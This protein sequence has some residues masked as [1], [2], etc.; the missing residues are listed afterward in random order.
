MEEISGYKQD[1]AVSKVAKAVTVRRLFAYMKKYKKEVA[2]VLLLM[3][4]TTAVTMINPL[5]VKAAVDD[6]I[7][8][9]D[10]AGLLRL[11]ALA[12]GLNLILAVCLRARIL[13]MGKVSNY[14]LLEI[15]QELYTHIQSLGFSFFDKRPTGK[16]L[17][18]VIGD[19]NSLKEVLNNAVVTLVPEVVNILAVLVIMLALNIR[20]ALAG[21]AMLPILA[22]GM[23]VVEIFA[24]QRWQLHRQKNSNMNA[25]THEDFSGISVVQSF[26][27]EGKTSKN[28]GRLLNEVKDSFFQA[29]ILTDLFWPI[30][31]LSSGIGTFL[32][33]YWG[34]PLVRSG[35][36]SV[37]L[38]IAFI[39]YIQMFWLPIINLS[40]F[41]NQ[42][43]SNLA[44][45]ERV[46]EILDTEPEEKEEDTIPMPKIKGDIAFEHV[47]FSYDGE[48]VV[49]DDVSFTVEKGETIALV[50]PTGE[51]K[52][53][54]INALARFYEIKS[55]CIR[56]DGQDI[57]P[58]S[59][60]SLRS[61][62]GIMTQ[63]TVL[64]TG[65][66]ADNIRYGKL[67]ASQAEIEE[68]AKAV[69]LHDFVM[70]L[71]KGYETMIND[72]GSKL[73]AGQ[74]QLI[75]FARTM[76]A[77][78]AVLILD[79]ATA[80][81]DTHTERLIQQGIASLLKDRTSFIVAHRLS[82]IKQASRI[83]FIKNRRIAEMGSHQELL[84]KKGDYYH[85]YM[86]Q[87]A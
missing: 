3:A 21:V 11:L 73:S 7:S 42:L 64:F 61:Q 53:T 55:G 83:F 8:R 37:G 63:D 78:P 25:F 66:I 6:Y 16:I 47:T 10:V 85:L 60:S 35:E 77:R 68:A 12:V 31:L 38:M 14:V 4:V 74:K 24:H 26:T 69:Q 1:E 13:I 62:M 23:Y 36:V 34:I 67:D 72:K 29:A 75:A 50:G 45:A 84:D 5:L 58:V 76:I 70:S 40:Q 59:L 65:T 27:A 86:A 51:G 15:R 44:A 82:T 46:F 43:T 22:A 79:E 9:A 87:R 54:I 2:L 30:V 19:V 71:E 33:F 81:I 49:L 80:S 56:I 32:I 52:T 17:A 57:R 20:L 39:S 48:K 18:R 28:F 41:Y